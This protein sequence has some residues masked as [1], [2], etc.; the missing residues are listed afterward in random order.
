MERN[1][2]EKEGKQKKERRDKLRYSSVQKDRERKREE[3]EEGGIESKRERQ[4]EREREREKSC[5]GGERDRTGG[6]SQYQVYYHQLVS[7]S[8]GST[9]FFFFFP[10]VFPRIYPADIC[11]VCF[12]S[13]FFFC[14]RWSSLCFLRSG[15]SSTVDNSRIGARSL[16]RRGLTCSEPGGK[17]WEMRRSRVVVSMQVSFL[18]Q[19]EYNTEHLY[20]QLRKRERERGRE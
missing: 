2:R 4:E 13:F 11:F 14:R 18:L 17:G 6:I 15:W 9:N 5:S 7:A 16:V 3:E 8:A 1:N 20:V 10:I 19:K 12:S